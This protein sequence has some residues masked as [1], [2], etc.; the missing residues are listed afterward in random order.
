MRA[1]LIALAGVGVLATTP[2][3][4]QMYPPDAPVCLQVFGRASYMEC[5]YATIAQ[6]RLSASGRPAQ[7]IENPFFVGQQQPGP[8]RERRTPRRY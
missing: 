5:R 7:C 8:R 6:C 3:S 2:A 1:L 4:A